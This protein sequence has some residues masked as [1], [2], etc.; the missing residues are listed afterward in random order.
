MTAD[1]RG[2]ARR[3]NA[4]A[5]PEAERRPARPRPELAA[6]PEARQK[7]VRV[8]GLPAVAALFETDPSRVER[9]FY[10]REQAAAA[11]AFC[12]E[13][14][15]RRLPYR[16]V[17]TPELD[18][19]AGTILHGGIVAVARPKP[20]LP[21]DVREAERWAA[22][23]EH[24]LILDG[25]GNPHN[26][27]A[28]LRTAAFFGIARVALS[29]HPAQ[30]G[31]SD[32][33]YRVAEGGFEFVTLYRA[34]DLPRQLKRLRASHRVAGTV[35]EGGVAPDGAGPPRPTALIL[36]NEEVGLDAATRAA[37]DTLITIG[38]AGRVQSLNVSAAAAILID[39]LQRRRPRP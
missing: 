4:A 24:L 31:P 32:A 35:A 19:V 10:E 36:G 39:A 13:L 16:L 5:R 30:A 25:I 3:G 9:L 22:A 23:G 7:L 37:C 34:A 11:G 38:G 20:V 18:R 17:A 28:I 14:A 26:L 27:G 8:A 21:F 1:K 15:A 2:K 6:A 33:S 29:D 12:R